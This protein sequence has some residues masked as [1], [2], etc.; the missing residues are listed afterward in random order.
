MDSNIFRLSYAPVVL[1]E[2]AVQPGGSKEVKLDLSTENAP[3]ELTGFPY[4]ID[5]ALKVFD[6]VFV[7]KIPCSLT[8]GMVPNLNISL[9]EYKTVLSAADIVKNQEV[10]ANKLPLN[11]F[12][13]HLKNNNMC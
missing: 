8:I 5:C 2:V 9:E 4:F 6:D 1:S 12:V 7:F 11:E 3:A 13:E 10:L